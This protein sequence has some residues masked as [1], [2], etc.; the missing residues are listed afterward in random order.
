MAAMSAMLTQDVQTLMA[1]TIVL[2]RMDLLEM[3]AP[4]QVHG[5]QF[6]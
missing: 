2:V 6:Y 3:D 1:L 4:V 5:I